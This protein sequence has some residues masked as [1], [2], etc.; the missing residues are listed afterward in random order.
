MASSKRQSVHLL[1]AF[2]LP[3][4][5]QEPF[6]FLRERLSAQAVRCIPV[7]SGMWVAAS[8]Q[9]GWLFAEDGKSW[10]AAKVEKQTEVVSVDFCCYKCEVIG[11]IKSNI[12]L[13]KNT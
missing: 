11:H 10:K 12:K 3:S 5:P 9:A 1:T 7:S 4:S 2:K 6:Q 13:H 8:L